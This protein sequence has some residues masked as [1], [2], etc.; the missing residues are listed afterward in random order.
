[1]VAADV[2][3]D[4]SKIVIVIV[5]ASFVIVSV[6]IY[7]SWRLIAKLRGNICVTSS[8]DFVKYLHLSLSCVSSRIR[9]KEKH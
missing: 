2:K 9:Q 8:L 4:F 3:K 5:V 1:M 7:I 6:G